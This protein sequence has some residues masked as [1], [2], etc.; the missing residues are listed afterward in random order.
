MTSRKNHPTKHQSKKVTV[1]NYYT[2]SNIRL[3]GLFV[4]TLGIYPMYWFYKNWRALEAHSDRKVYPRLS[5][6]LYHFFSYDLYTNVRRHAEE[7]KTDIKVPAGL[8]AW[9]TFFLAY[10]Y[11]SFLPMMVIQGH[12][13]AIKTKAFGDPHIHKGMS[14]GIYILAGLWIAYLILLIAGTV[15]SGD[16]TTS[17]QPPTNSNQSEI[18]AKKA[19]SDSLTT[20]YDTCSSNLLARRDS[21]DTY[22]QNAVDA[23]NTDY[24]NCENI[25]VQQNAAADAYNSLLK[26]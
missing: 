8:Y 21:V 1:P 3:F 25:R 22:D 14:K 20:Q 2:V 19:A 15:F 17:I 26:Q 11:L 23:Y 16:Q 9:A 5:A 13:N 6:V 4:L 24:Q 10:I 18:D 7:T 12:M